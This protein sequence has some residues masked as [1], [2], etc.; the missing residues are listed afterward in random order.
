[1]LLNDNI[2]LRHEKYLVYLQVLGSF[3]FTLL[4]AQYFKIL[5]IQTPIFNAFIVNNFTIATAIGIGGFIVLRKKLN[6][7]EDEK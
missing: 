5:E 1:M 6:I 2:K 4:A 7:I 3:C